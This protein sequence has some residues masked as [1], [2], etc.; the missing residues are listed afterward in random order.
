VGEIIVVG[1]SVIREN[2][3]HE[4]RQVIVVGTQPKAVVTKKM[5]KKSYSR[6]RD[7]RKKKKEK[8]RPGLG[9]TP[10]PHCFLKRERLRYMRAV[11]KMGV[12]GGGVGIPTKRVGRVR[13]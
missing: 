2:G 10:S 7:P 3:C 4:K 13:G 8:K 5:E 6:G 11:G 1:D 9:T 12:K